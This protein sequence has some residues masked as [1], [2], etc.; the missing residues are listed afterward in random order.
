MGFEA[1]KVKIGHTDIYADLET[2][3]ALRGV[4]GDA[5]LA[6]DYNR[7]RHPAEAPPVDRG[8][9]AEASSAG[10]GRVTGRPAD[11]TVRGEAD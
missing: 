4:V 8:A 6:V 11:G 5:R 3:N 7:L 2:V 9:E 10:T 1:Y